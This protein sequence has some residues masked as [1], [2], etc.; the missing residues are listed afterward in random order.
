L[1]LFV[2]FLTEFHFDK[3]R[4]IIQRF[5][6]PL[7]DFIDSSQYGYIDLGS[8]GHKEP[9]NMQPVIASFSREKGQ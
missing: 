5:T 6:I 4:Y 8:A 2:P 9:Y 3:Y 1:L 7:Q